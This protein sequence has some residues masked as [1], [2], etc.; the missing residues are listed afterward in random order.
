ME[1]CGGELS[2][3]NMEVRLTSILIPTMKLSVNQHLLNGFI[4]HH[5]KDIHMVDHIHK[6]EETGKHI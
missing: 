4:L 3:E 1:L 5:K 2:Q 6:R